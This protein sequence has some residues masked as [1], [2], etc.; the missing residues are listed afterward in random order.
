MLIRSSMRI[1]KITCFF[2]VLLLFTGLVGSVNALST[3]TVSFHGVGV[4]IDLSFPEEAQP[5][6]NIWHNATITANSALFVRNLTVVIKAPVNSSWQEVLMLKDDQIA[7]FIPADGSYQWFSGPIPLPK[8]TNGKM[9][10]FMY[11]NTSQSNDY[12][13]GTF[14]TTLVS[15]PTFSEM[16]ANYTALKNNYDSLL[17]NY[18]SLFANYTTLDIEHNQLTTDYNSKVAAHALLL[19]QYNRLSSDNDALINNYESKVSELGALQTDYEDLN[20]TRY[21]LQSDFD[22]LQVV[23]NGLN[24]TYTDLQTE[25]TTLQQSIDDSVGELNIN[26]I[27]MFIFTVAVAVLI[28]FI[29]Y[30]K[31]KKEEPYVVIRK[32]TVSMKSDEES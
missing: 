25:I 6:E 2:S 27:I 7:R 32:E 11:L 13:A 30:L 12:V 26:R 21:N 1:K 17:A 15:K 23:Y 3:S 4:T 8:E 22:L 18:N 29:I 24:Q 10:C 14:F 31:R 16:L 28:A 9:H 20:S 5:S 19:A